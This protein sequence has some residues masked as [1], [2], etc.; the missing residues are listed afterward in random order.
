MNLLKRDV[1]TMKRGEGSPY[2]MARM[3]GALT[4]DNQ[5][6][7]N[8]PNRSKYSAEKWQFFL[9]APFEICHRCCNV[10]KKNPAHEYQRRTGRKS[11]T[12]MMAS[13]SRLR[14]Q[15]WLLHGCNGFDMKQPVSNPM[16]FWTESD[17][18]LYLWVNQIPIASCYGEIVKENEIEGQLDFADLGLFDL[19]TPVLT[20]TGCKRTGCMFCGFGCHLEKQ[21]EGRFL[22]MKETHPKQYDY[23]MRPWDKG[24]LGYKEVIDWINEHGDLHIQY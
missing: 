1:G 24:G 8:S 22:K 14:T 15:Q 6:Q 18:L 3:L 12:A 7:E 21:G 16:A 23:I 5:I 10:M 13:E 11:M 20:T 19:G 9:D 4:Q 2:R 17:V